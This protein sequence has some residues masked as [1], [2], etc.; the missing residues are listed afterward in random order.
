MARPF[1]KWVG[2]KTKLL[3]EILHRV[4]EFNRYHEPFLGGGAVFF[5]VAPTAACLSDLN[6]HLVTTYV[7]VRDHV[8]CVMERL[9]ALQSSHTDGSYGRVRSHYNHGSLS[10]IERAATFLYLNKTCFNGL[11]R[12]NKK[13]EFNSPEGDYDIS[14]IVDE[15]T[16]RAA[17]SALGNADI[18]CQGFDAAVPTEGDFVYLD[19]PYVPVSTTSAFTTYAGDF[20]DAHQVQLRDLVMAWTH[21][22][23]KVM[24]SNSAAPRVLDLYSHPTFHVD[25]VKAPRSINSDAEGRG[26]VDEVLVRNYDY[27]L[28]EPPT[29]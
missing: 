23:V 22:G 16:L 14:A 9:Y 28:P 25:I 12:L 24:L 5:G 11:H 3:P 1:F 26:V 13:G 29:W 20:T 27:V 17:S 10:D 4:P 2:G 6:P 21:A 15:P 8:D 19:P 7:A 18:R